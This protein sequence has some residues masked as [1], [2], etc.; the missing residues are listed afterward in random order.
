MLKI[1]DKVAGS[2][3]IP[4][5]AAGD[6]VPTNRRWCPIVTERA[7]EAPVEE[8]IK[9]LGYLVY[10]PR[11]TIERRD[12]KKHRATVPT[13]RPLFPRIVFARFDPDVDPWGEIKRTKGVKD[14]LFIAGRLAVARDAEIAAMKEREGINFDIDKSGRIKTLLPPRPEPGDTIRITKGPF[15]GFFAKVATI[16]DEARLIAL[17]EL[18]RRETPIELDADQYEGAKTRRQAGA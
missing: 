7:K 18:F 5:R 11:F 12:P 15:E 17:V 9:S 2:I 16:D 14:L 1:G 13:I 10:V 3:V 4:A 8:K 6:D